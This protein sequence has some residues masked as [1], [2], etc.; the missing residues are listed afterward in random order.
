MWTVSVVG[1]SGSKDTS[2][3]WAVMSLVF[4]CFFSISRLVEERMYP[5]C[6][7]AGWRAFAKESLI[8]LCPAFLLIFT[9]LKVWSPHRSCICEQMQVG[10]SFD[11]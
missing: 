7:R 8:M 11:C 3:D 2:K 5:A 9:H 4:M 6:D 1:W 10:V